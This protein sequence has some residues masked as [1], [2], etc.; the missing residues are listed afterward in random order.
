MIVPKRDPD[1]VAKDLLPAGAEQNN[2]GGSHGQGAQ[3]PSGAIPGAASPAMAQRGTLGY[4]FRRTMASAMLVAMLGTAFRVGANLI[5][6]PLILTF[7]TQEQQAVWWVFLALGDFANLAD[8]G[9]GQVIQRVYSV[10]WAGAEDFESVGLKPATGS[11][12]PNLKRIAELNATVRLLYRRIAL[13]G[14]A[15]LALAGTLYLMKV[16]A[17]MPDHRIIWLMWAAYLVVIGFNLGTVHW[18]FASQ[19]TNRVREMHLALLWSNMAYLLVVS[20]LLWA[21]LGLVAM[22][23]S[24]ALRAFMLRM[25]ARRAYHQ[26]VPRTEGMP[27]TPNPQMLKRLWPNSWKFGVQALGAYFLVKTPVLICASILGPATTASFGLTSKIGDFVCGLAPLWLIVKWPQLTVLRTQ[28]RL[29]EMAVLF[30]RR[31][32]LSMLTFAGLALLVMLLGNTLLAAK[33]TST[34]LLPLPYQAVF[35]AYL[36]LH[37]FYMNWAMLVMTENTVPFFKISVATGLGMVGV[38]LILTRL[39][40]LWGLLLSPLLAELACNAWYSIRAGLRCQPLN[41]RQLIR[42]VAL[43]RA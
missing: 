36:S 30:A 15:I 33:G 3:D 32:A 4:W 29:A 25:L 17:P 11:R 28:G 10:L 41:G 35:F 24:T 5:I 21:R 9:F 16:L 19:G 8:F 7:L 37:I 12:E 26:V 42:A 27:S 34:R 31:L 14:C 18:M 43:W 13:G 22:I 20:L 1:D 6:L 2:A 40:G 39:W 23:A 38:S